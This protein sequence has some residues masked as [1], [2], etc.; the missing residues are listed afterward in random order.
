MCDCLPWHH[1]IWKRAAKLAGGVRPMAVYG[2]VVALH[3]DPLIAPLGIKDK[4]AVLADGAGERPMTVA[5]ILSALQHLGVVDAAGK[6][7]AQADK[8]ADEMTKLLTKLADN[9][10]TR[11]PG[12]PPLGNRAMTGAERTARWKANHRAAVGADDRSAAT[13]ETPSTI[14]SPTPLSLFP[15]D[16][17]QEKEQKQTR[18]RDD[19][20][21]GFA[22]LWAIWPIADRLADAERA[23]QDYRRRHSAARVLDAAKKYLAKKPAWQTT[24]MLFHWLRSDPCRDPVLPLKAE[25][26]EVA[27]ESGPPKVPRPNWVQRLS[28]LK[29]TS[30]WPSE[31][32]PCW[33]EPGCLVP[34]GTGVAQGFAIWHRDNQHQGYRETG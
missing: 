16:H 30:E 26:R 18:A 29:E 20:I 22:E 13:D 3:D 4:V 5:P 27:P 11:G 15:E 6:V 2:I 33:G 24:R 10:V 28:Q 32:G 34:A 23:Y 19:E 14:S 8:T 7:V 17:N 31:W 12:R 21:D 1:P 9:F 25:L